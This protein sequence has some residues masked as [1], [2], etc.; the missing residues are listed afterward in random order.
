VHGQPGG[1]L[2]FAGELALDLGESGHQGRAALH[3]LVLG[4]AT[5]GAMPSGVLFS[6]FAAE[7]SVRRVGERNS[8]SRP[9]EGRGTGWP[10]QPGNGPFH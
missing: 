10:P 6:R 1:E 9:T 7:R 8:P 4:H 2:A 5:S 3:L